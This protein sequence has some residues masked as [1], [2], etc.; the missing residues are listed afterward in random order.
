MLLFSE[1][2]SILSW[3]I[4]AVPT[5][6]PKKYYIINSFLEW[7]FAT[8][9]PKFFVKSSQHRFILWPFTVS[10]YGVS[11]DH[12]V[13]PSASYTSYCF[14]KR[15]TKRA[16]KP[17]PQLS[18]WLDTVFVDPFPSFRTICLCETARSASEKVAYDCKREP[19]LVFVFFSVLC[20]SNSV[21]SDWQWKSCSHLL[22]A[23]SQSSPWIA[24]NGSVSLSPQ[25]MCCVKKKKKISATAQSSLGGMKTVRSSC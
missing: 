19:V 8:W 7:T 5:P 25:E 12:Y 21:S 11:P 15:F 9:H 6:P 2:L 23:A 22:L 20:E 17:R 16:T 3:T 14:L 13:C 24:S 10:P 18:V 4:K 1:P